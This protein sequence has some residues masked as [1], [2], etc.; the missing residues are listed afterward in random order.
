MVVLIFPG[1]PMPVVARVS[2]EA[3]T[4]AAPATTGEPILGADKE[5]LARTTA[6]EAPV[7]KAAPM[8]AGGATILPVHQDQTTTAILL[9]VAKRNARESGTACVPIEHTCRPESLPTQAG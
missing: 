8:E 7:P 6:V 3:P 2:P 4:A 5:D 9:A 1:A